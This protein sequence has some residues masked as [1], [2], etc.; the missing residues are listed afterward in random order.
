[1]GR[2]T[3]DSPPSPTIWLHTEAGN[4]HEAREESKLIDAVEVFGT[5]KPERLLSRVLALATKPGDIVLDSF[6][7]SGTT[8]AVAH[9][10][11][12]RYIGIEMGEHARTHCVPRLQK[13]IAGEQ[14]GISAAVGWKGGGGFRF[15]TLS[16]AA[17]D[18]DGRINPEVRFGTL[19]AFIWHFETATPA[20]KTFNKPLLGRHNGTA[21]YL[22]YN[23]ILGDK[24]PQGGNVL[25]HAVLQMLNEKYPHDGPRVIYGET[26]RLGDA[27]LSAEGVTFKQ[28]PYDI[29]MR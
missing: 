7:G 21:Y 3:I 23:G 20:A 24:R 6:L 5:P 4:N 27:K 25:T 12:R 1:L 11:G 8:A 13:V 26:T 29:K 18:A 2:L 16:Q 10:M 19:A 15:C 9:K 22:L 28:I 14:G 17:F